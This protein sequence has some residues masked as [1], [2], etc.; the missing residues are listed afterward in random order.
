MFCLRSYVILV[1]SSGM[2]P[3]ARHPVTWKFLPVHTICDYWSTEDDGWCKYTYNRTKKRQKRCSL[4]KHSLKDSRRSCVLIW[5][6]EWFLE[7]TFTPNVKC[8]VLN[9]GESEARYQR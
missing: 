6:T 4:R 5:I 9:R 1:F 7:P 8:N 2:C 3:H